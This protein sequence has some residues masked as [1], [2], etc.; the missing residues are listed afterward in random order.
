MVSVAATNG[1]R[2]QVK[3]HP[4]A[5][6][7]K[8]SHKN[9]STREDQIL[10]ARAGLIPAPE[11]DLLLQER[12]HSVRDVKQPA[13]T[14]AEAATIFAALRVFQGI[15]EGERTSFTAAGLREMEYFEDV[16]PLKPEE[17][18]ALCERLNTYPAKGSTAAAA[19][20]RG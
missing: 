10:K 6:R 4:P 16:E 9:T 8:S 18:D 17:I 7:R 15:S 3:N 2:E 13:M 19:K 1:R 12:Y 20:L 5:S 14:Y 11:N